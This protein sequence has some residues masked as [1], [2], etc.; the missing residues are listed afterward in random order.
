MVDAAQVPPGMQASPPGQAPQVP[1]Q[2]SGPQLTPSQAAK[3]TS[4]VRQRPCQGSGRR[5][6]S[7]AQPSGQ[8]AALVQ[9]R[10]Q[11]PPPSVARQRLLRQSS[12]AAQ[13]RPASAAPGRQVAPA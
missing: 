1:P 10:V 2:P 3:Q 4:W 6:P 12:S 8:W 11:I 7:Q 13:G 9:A 5:A